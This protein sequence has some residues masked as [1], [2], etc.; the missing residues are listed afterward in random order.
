[1]NQR[2]LEQPAVLRKDHLPRRRVEI[3][4]LIVAL[5]RGRRELVAQSHVERQ[6]LRRA[7]VVLDEVEL[8]VLPLIH[9]GVARQRELRRQA[10]QE[11]AHG[12]VGKTVFKVHAADRRVE[13]VDL[14]LHVQELAAELE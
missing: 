10:Q 2:S 13:I 12:A 4:H 6:L 11:I 7:I 1:M 3:G 9:H 5:A 8:H 14:R